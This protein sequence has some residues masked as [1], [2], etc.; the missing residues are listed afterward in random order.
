MVDRDHRP[1][2]EAAS[3]IPQLYWRVTFLSL[4]EK[5]AAQAFYAMAPKAVHID[6]DHLKAAYRFSRIVNHHQ[7]FL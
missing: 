1:M 2:G 3:L 7:G 5:R 4:R 6:P